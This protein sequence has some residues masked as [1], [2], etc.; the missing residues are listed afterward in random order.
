MNTEGLELLKAIKHAVELNAAKITAMDETL[1]R[2]EGRITGIEDGQK[3][4]ERLLERLALGYVE[5]TAEIQDL[6]RVRQQPNP[7]LDPDVPRV[8][9]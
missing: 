2:I 1:T 4:H 6:R 7:V 3:R 8:R 5:N 9:L